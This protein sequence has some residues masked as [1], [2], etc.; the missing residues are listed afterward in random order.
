MTARSE[1]TPELIE[2]L[3]PAYRRLLRMARES[4]AAAE[5]LPSGQ[6]ERLICSDSQLVVRQYDRD[7][8]CYELTLVELLA[9]LDRAAGFFE[10]VALEWVP[11]ERN[12]GADALARRGL[13]LARHRETCA[14]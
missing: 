13:E 3:L 11:R 2:R 9:K 4:Q 6:E 5:T 7:Y 1:V 10:D 12:G 14:S 8:G